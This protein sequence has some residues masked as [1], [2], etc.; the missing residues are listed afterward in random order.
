MLPF[1]LSAAMND[2][3]GTYRHHLCHRP[4]QKMISFVLLSTFRELWLRRSYIALG[5]EKKS[6]L[7]LFIS[8]VFS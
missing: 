4:Q 6:K 1:P 8:L 3:A 5:N 7:F 2:A